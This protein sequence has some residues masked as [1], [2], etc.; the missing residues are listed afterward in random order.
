MYTGVFGGQETGRSRDRVLPDIE[1]IW[2]GEEPMIIVSPLTMP[3]PSVK[4]DASETVTEV[5]PQAEVVWVRAEAAP[6][7]GE[8]GLGRPEGSRLGSPEMLP[9]NLARGPPKRES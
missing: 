9:S 1:V 7:T 4:K 5:P 8:P 3:Q 6:I 2:A